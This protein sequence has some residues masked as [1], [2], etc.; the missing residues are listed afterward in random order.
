MPGLLFLVKLAADADA[1][2][3]RRL[4]FSSKRLDFRMATAEKKLTISAKG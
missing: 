3:S 1:Y 2:L 4:C